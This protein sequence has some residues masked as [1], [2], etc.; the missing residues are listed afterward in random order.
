MALFD[1]SNTGLACSS[2]IDCR[3]VFR[4]HS[5]TSPYDDRTIFH[6]LNSQIPIVVANKL[7]QTTRPGIVILANQPLFEVEYAVK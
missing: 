4:W 3:Q 5:K 6:N 2:N 7:W 1:Q